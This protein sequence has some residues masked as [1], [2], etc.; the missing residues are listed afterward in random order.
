MRIWMQIEMRV[1][2]RTSRGP[3]SARGVDCRRRLDARLSTSLQHL[4]TVIIQVLPMASSYVLRGM[5]IAEWAPRAGCE[6][7]STVRSQ[8][9]RRAASTSPS[10]ARATTCQIRKVRMPRLST[11]SMLCCCVV[12]P[13]TLLHVVFDGEEDGRGGRAWQSDGAGSVRAGGRWVG[14]RAVVGGRA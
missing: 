4:R 5:A 11:W 14:A 13:A 1:E 2:M 8:R 9:A 6:R 10:K 12:V 3:Q 7:A